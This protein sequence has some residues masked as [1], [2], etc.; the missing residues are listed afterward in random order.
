M[1]DR[2][3]RFVRFARAAPA[4]MS[5]ASA[6]T[7][8]RGLMRSLDDGTPIQRATGEQLEIQG[9]GPVWFLQDDFIL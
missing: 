7:Q 6:W 9:V 1:A 5:S 4:R 3:V 8:V 2:N